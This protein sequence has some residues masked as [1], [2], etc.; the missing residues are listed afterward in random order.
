MD[1]LD[2]INWLKHRMKVFEFENFL[3]S[4]NLNSVEDLKANWNDPKVQEEIQATIKRKTLPKDIKFKL[5]PEP[6]PVIQKGKYAHVK[7]YVSMS[8]LDD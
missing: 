2:T 4:L 8:L 5:D 1:M 7:T 3:Y 6:A